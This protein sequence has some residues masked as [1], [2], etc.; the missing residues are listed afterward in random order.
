[1][2]PKK[3]FDYFNDNSQLEGEQINFDKKVQLFVLDLFRVF[4]GKGIGL[5]TLSIT[6]SVIKRAA[7][8]AVQSGTA[9]VI[10]NFD[11]TSV[12]HKIYLLPR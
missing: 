2:Q 3:E 6:S 5:Q 10:T 8:V 1:M 7:V 11:K 12:R 4:N 9:F